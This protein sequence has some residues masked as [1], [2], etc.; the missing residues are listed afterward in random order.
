MFDHVVIRA[1]DRAATRRFYDCVLE[2]LGY[3]ATPTGAGYDAWGN[4]FTAQADGARPPTRRLHVAFSAHTRDVV[5]AFW[6]SGVDA[7]YTSD[8]E[9]GLRPQYSEDYYGAF[10]LD[11][12]GNS[13]EA[14]THERVREGAL[15]HLWI[16]VADLAATL[17]FYETIAPI[18]G[19]RLTSRLPERF[20]V[21]G[22]DAS[23]ALV[24]GSRPTENVHLA[25]PAPDDETVREFYRVALS[26][27]YRDN[28]TPGDR[29][30]YHAGYYGA[31]V[32]DPDGNN[33]EAVNHHR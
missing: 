9:P 10:L 17:R 14:V 15:D 6:R 12:D 20:H 27:G 26:A 8:G 5:D 11:P 23:M 3:Q 25:F 30:E 18:L 21:A 16:R 28:G 24:R 1:A 22:R 13:A 32:L 19:L 31:F 29:P 7:G 33:V 2:P 4:F